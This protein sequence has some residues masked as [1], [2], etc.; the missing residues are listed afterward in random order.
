MPIKKIAV[1]D[2]KD[3]SR[4]EVFANVVRYKLVNVF[5]D[6][7]YNGRHW[8]FKEDFNL[9]FVQLPS[10]K[11][12][13]IGA[14]ELIAKEIGVPKKA[15]IDNESHF[16]KIWELFDKI[17]KARDSSSDLTP[18]PISL[19]IVEGNNTKSATNQE[20][21]NAKSFSLE[22]EIEKPG[23]YE[24]VVDLNKNERSLHKV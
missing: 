21:I 8:Y 4:T 11:K 6:Y 16:N 10:V 24:I 5:N 22:F 18:K 7:A 15:L 20:I 2:S 3:L 23:H 14:I 19:A 1:L 17:E 13:P 9:S 12:V